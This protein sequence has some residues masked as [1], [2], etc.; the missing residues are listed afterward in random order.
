MVQRILS[1]HNCFGQTN[2][3]YKAYRRDADLAELVSLE[4]Y[5]FEDV[6]LSISAD[7]LEVWQFCQRNHILLVTGNRSNDDNELSLESVI[8]AEF[9]PTSLPV[10]T[11]GNLKRV[12][13]N[14]KYRNACAERLATIVFD[15]DDY[16]GRMR[17]YLPS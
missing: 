13:P 5:R 3:I 14:L 11:I 1:D 12:I 16:R 6:G 17:L 4:L 15:L 10:I 7:D 2:A 9:K 8:R